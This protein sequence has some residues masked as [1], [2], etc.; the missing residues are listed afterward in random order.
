MLLR[1]VA[2]CFLFVSNQ[3]LFWLC[4]CVCVCAHMCFALANFDSFVD[5]R[6][7]EPGFESWSIR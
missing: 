2:C 5:G 3:V 4:V 7:V 1:C 6:G